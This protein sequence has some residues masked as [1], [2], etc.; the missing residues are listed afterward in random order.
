MNRFKLIMKAAVV[1]LGVFCAQGA[2]QFET[3]P[4][5]DICARG[6]I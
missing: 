5:A 2:P 1:T 4:P 3:L 6:C